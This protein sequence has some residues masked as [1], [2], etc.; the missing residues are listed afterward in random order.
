ME[1]FNYAIG[2]YWDD[3]EQIGAYTYFGQVHYGFR[4]DAENFLKCVQR[5][6]PDHNWKIFKIMEIT[7]A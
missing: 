4:E 6:T 7:N 5:T 2:H 3:S 1:K